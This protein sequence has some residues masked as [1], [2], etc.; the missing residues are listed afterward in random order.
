MTKDENGSRSRARR[1]L[2]GFRNHLLGYFA[3]MIVLV[4][5]NFLTT[6]GTPWFLFPMVGWGALL[7]LHAAWAMGLFDVFTKRK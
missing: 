5:V 3:V 6:P 2:A 1:R 4:P 7:G